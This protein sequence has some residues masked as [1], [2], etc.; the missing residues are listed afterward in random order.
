MSDS[1][2]ASEQ[3]NYGV[4]RDCCLIMVYTNMDYVV[5][6]RLHAYRIVVG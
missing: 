1:A 4:E 5:A 2:N 3:A 6:N